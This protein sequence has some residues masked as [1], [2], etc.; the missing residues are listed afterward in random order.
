VNCNNNTN[1]GF[2]L[3][4]LLIAVAI[5][6]ILSAIAVP[7]YGKY[8]AKGTLTTAQSDLALLSLKYENRYQRMLS[9]PTTAK[10]DTAGLK[11]IVPTWMPASDQS[12]FEFSSSNAT[13]ATYKLTATG[14]SSRVDG[15]A[16]NIDHQ[17]NKSITNCPQLS[18]DGNWL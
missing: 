11:E 7:S 16:I 3:I 10:T 4:E 8:I 18:S 12:D 6:G 1:K 9:Y 14:K 17:G 2:S 13:G 5:V 15:C